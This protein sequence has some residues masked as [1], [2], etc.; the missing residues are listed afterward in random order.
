MLT[1][2]ATRR[3]CNAIDLSPQ[4]QPY[5]VIHETGSEL[6]SAAYR[7]AATGG[8]SYRDTRNVYLVIGVIKEAMPPNFALNKFLVPLECKTRSSAIAQ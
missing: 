4:G 8:P 3:R 2:C 1:T 5:Y 7:C 6:L